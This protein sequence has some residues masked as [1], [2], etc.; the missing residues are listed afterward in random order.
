M[1]CWICESQT[2]ELWKDRNLTR[3]LKPEDLQI[4]DNR[5]GTTLRLWRCTSCGFIFADGEELNQLNSL[6]S[7]MSDSAYTAGTDN[8]SL[9]M[10]WLLD[11]VLQQRPGIRSALEIGAGVGLLISELT[12]RGIQADGIEPSHALVREAKKNGIDLIQGFFPHP[13]IANRKY[14]AIFIVDVIEHVGD[15]LRLLRNTVSSLSPGGIAVVVTPDIGSLAAR[16][17][18]KHWWH[19]RLAHVGYFNHSVMARAS[20]LAGF[21]ISH[22]FRPLWFFPVRYLAERLAVYLPIGWLNRIASD[23]PLLKK[24]Y[25]RTVPVNLADSHVFVLRKL[26]RQPTPENL[27][28]GVDTFPPDGRSA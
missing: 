22:T 10:K 28:V 9:Q 16:L 3:P 19:L 20:E 24:L 12:A 7:N 26:D 27:L 14:D 4:T 2:V 1:N 5:Y 25:A 23:L 15:P 13:H 8:R 21:E 6:Y 11:K 18:G 17:L